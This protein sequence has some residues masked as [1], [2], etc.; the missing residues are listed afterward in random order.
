MQGY[1]EMQL[2]P[3]ARSREILRPSNANGGAA[4]VRR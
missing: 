2:Q 1:C 4:I 3:A